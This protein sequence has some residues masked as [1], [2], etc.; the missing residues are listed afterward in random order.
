MTFRRLLF[1]LHLATGLTVGLVI[2]FLAIT[3]A[4]MTFQPQIIAW[5]ERSARVVSPVSHPCA[6]PSTVLKNA[7]DFEHE[8]PTELTLFSDPH[9]PAEVAFGTRAYVLVNSCDGNVIGP[10][11]RLRNFF[12]QTR[13]LHR[14]IAFQGVRHETLR[15]IKNIAVLGFFCLIVSGLVIWF[16][17]KLTWQHLRPAIFFRGSL[18]GRAREWNWHNVFGFWMSLPLA[19]IA[20]SGIIMAYPWA[21]ALL[22]RAAGDT[23]PAARAELEPKRPKPLAVEKFPTL[24]A[25]IAQATIQDPKWKMLSMRLP[26]DKDPN[27]L[28]TL[29]EGDGSRPQ[30]RAQLVLTREKGQVV[31]WEP[32]SKNVRGRRWRLYA[33]FL[34]TGEIFGA[35]GRSVALL[36]MLSL[37]M[38]VWTGFSLSV[39][40]LA[41]WKT[42]KATHRKTMIRKKTE[43][44]QTVRI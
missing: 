3:G 34:H 24:N 23:P 39:R 36:A 7:A 16:P 1:W 9:R 28:F 18:L 35:V 42:R 15:R 26:A 21:N 11:N 40:R 38:L 8:V 27:V 19:V 37:L 10:G 25:V 43:S 29:D 4:I 32:F 33:R 12:Q 44:P 31:R 14:W 22:Y 20:L 30:D 13:D 41:A 17:R 5:A 6:E 2:V